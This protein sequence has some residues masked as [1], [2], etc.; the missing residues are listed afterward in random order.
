MATAKRTRR[1]SRPEPANGV[2]IRQATLDD[3]KALARFYAA[4]YPATLQW[5]F[6]AR[7]WWE[8]QYNP[9]GP[10]DRLPMWVAEDDG[11]IVGQS[12]A[13]CVRCKVGEDTVDAAWGVDFYVLESHR[14]RGI[15]RDLQRANQDSQKLFMSL[16]MADSTRIIKSQIGQRPFKSMT[17][18]ARVERIAPNDFDSTVERAL[19]KRVSA[20]K[21][22]A[23]TRALRVSR[24]DRLGAAWLA[25]RMRRP[26]RRT[27]ADGLRV[28]AVDGRFDERADFLWR[29]IRGDWD[30]AVERGR[31]HLNWKYRDQPYMDYQ[32]AYVMRGDDVVGLVAYRVPKDP[33]RRVGVIAEVLAVDESPPVYGLAIA[34]AVE[35][36]RATG[37]DAMIVGAS[38]EPLGAA[39]RR[40]GFFA[41]DEYVP[42]AGGDEAVVS[43]VVDARRVLLSLGDDDIDQYPND[44]LPK[45][46]MLLKGARRAS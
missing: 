24:V 30:V 13:M 2:G 35:E 25:R 36:L 8:F 46:W 43:Q 15:G 9:F 19:R 16:G 11:E 29:K 37:V 12:A 23:V 20:A 5:R 7:W 3:R 18:F 44:Q 10:K 27:F 39:L 41:Y 17:L 40:A 1:Q 28:E 26:G 45:T 6:P 21:V 22:S 34:Y 42:L 31:E 4:A 38:S 14:G 33:E 32:A